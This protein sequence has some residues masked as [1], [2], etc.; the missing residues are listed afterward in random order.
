MKRMG[1]FCLVVGVLVGYLA[2]VGY[3]RWLEKKS[4][5]EL[6]GDSAEIEQTSEYESETEAETEPPRVYEGDGY[7]VIYGRTIY[8]LSEEEREKLR[9]PLV[10]LLSN[11]QKPVYDD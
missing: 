6:R 8:F 2:F 4:G 7:S 9:E 10:A 3:E 5:E 11:E 1:V